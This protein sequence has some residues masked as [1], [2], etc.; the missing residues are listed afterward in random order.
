M[1]WHPVAAVQHTY[2]HKQYAEYRE[3]NIH[4]NKKIKD[5]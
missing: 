1:S 5:T 4:N 2:T 3:H